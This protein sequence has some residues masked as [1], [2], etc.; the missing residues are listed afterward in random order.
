MV[1]HKEPLSAGGYVF[2]V[3]GGGLPSVCVRVDLYSKNCIQSVD[4]LGG[5]IGQNQQIDRKNLCMLLIYFSVQKNTI[6]FMIQGKTLQF[7]HCTVS[8]FQFPLPPQSCRDGKFSLVL[9]HQILSKKN[10]P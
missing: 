10:I 8:E 9:S 1:T 5:K 4:P 3:S 7:S 6:T 2:P